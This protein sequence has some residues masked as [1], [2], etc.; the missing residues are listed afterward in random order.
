MQWQKQQNARPKL[1]KLRTVI[2]KLYPVKEKS[3]VKIEE[4]KKDF[5]TV[6]CVRIIEHVD[7][8][9]LSLDREEGNQLF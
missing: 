7:Q 4:V 1:E 9:D 3:L 2:W 6:R 8:N 5:L